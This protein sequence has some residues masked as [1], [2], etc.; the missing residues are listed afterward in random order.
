MSDGYEDLATSAESYVEGIGDLTRSNVRKQ[1]E[2]GNF[3]P[4][5]KYLFNKYI[6]SCDQKDGLCFEYYISPEEPP[7][8]LAE[9]KSRLKDYLNRKP[10]SKAMDIVPIIMDIEKSYSD[11]RKNFKP[12]H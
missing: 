9:V 3:T 2:K 7:L 10:D 4:A 1:M 11:F 5:A 6:R 12:T 8:T